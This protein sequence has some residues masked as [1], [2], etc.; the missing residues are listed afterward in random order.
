MT[1]LQLA[2]RASGYAVVIT[3]IGSAAACD[4]CPPGAACPTSVGHGVVDANTQTYLYAPTFIRTDD[5]V[6]HYFACWGGSSLGGDQIGYKWAKTLDGLEQQSLKAVLAPSEQHAFD[7]KH[8]CDPSIV[9]GVEDGRYYLHYGG[10]SGVGVAVSSWLGGPYEKMGQYLARDPAAD[11]AAYGR[12]QPSVALGPDNWYYLIFTNQI[13]P[14][15][16]PSLVVLR[17]KDPSF[18]SGFEE[19]TRIDAGAVGGWSVHLS[20]DPAT[21]AFLITVPNGSDILVHS[22]DDDFKPRSSAYYRTALPVGEGVALLADEYQHPVQDLGARVFAF[23]THGSRA[24]A[25]A[26][27]TGPNKYER[28]IP[29]EASDECTRGPDPVAAECPPSTVMCAC[30]GTCMQAEKCRQ[31]C[32]PDR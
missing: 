26:H 27:V 21:A 5:G 11:P 17:S 14:V 28:F 6:Y 7:R 13:E 2:V 1:G 24:T 23:A 15:E 25:P 10:E 19:V 20:Y 16:P 31:F 18:L 30:N 4:G 29:A 8:T 32:E 12:G 9:R 3:L 22:Y